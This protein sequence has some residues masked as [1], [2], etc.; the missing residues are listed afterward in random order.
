MSSFQTL[1]INNTSFLI[2]DNGTGDPVL[3]VHGACGSVT[4]GEALASRLAG[5]YRFISYSQRFHLPNPPQADG[6]YN[7]DTHA[8]D[9]IALVETLGI[10]GCKVIGHSYGCSVILTA[11]AMRNE[12]FGSLY[13]AEPGLAFLL[14]NNDSYQKI[15][16][17]R[18]DTF[19]R[20][21]TC[22]EEGKS[23]D[24][25]STL[26]RYANGARGFIAFPEKIRW[27]MLANASSLH[28]LV[29]ESAMSTL[30]AEDLK[31]I[32]IPVKVLLGQHCTPVYKAVT[33]EIKK[34]IPHAEVKTIPDCA[35]DLVYVRPREVAMAIG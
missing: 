24:A 26:M 34:H 18:A 1:E 23:A 8:A 3:F 17:E 11:A 13:L 22:F 10:Q 25:V 4:H 21:K 6:A 2:C 35:H 32:T 9:L 19:R 30:Q 5:R 27:D 20:I 15:R 16:E 12:I 33:E 14:N 31:T 29:Y 7:A 28:R